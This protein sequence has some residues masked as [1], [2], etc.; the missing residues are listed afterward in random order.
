MINL[1]FQY[2]RFFT[3]K[4][5]N[6][7]YPNG[8]SD[9]FYIVPTGRTSKLIDKM[10][11]LVRSKEGEIHILFDASNLEQLTYKLN[12]INDSESKLSFIVFSNNPYFINITDIPA[13]TIDK[14]FYCSNK[15]LGNK[16]KGLL[17]NNEFIGS[18]D[19][20]PLI[21]EKITDY[22]ESSIKYKFLRENEDPEGVEINLNVNNDG[23]V[24]LSELLEGC[25]RIMGSDKELTS[26]IKLGSQI[27]G[28]PVGFV[29]IFLSKKM[30]QEII[31]EIEENEL[32]S[33]EYEINFN[34][35]HIYWKYLIVPTHIKRFKELSV[36]TQKGKDKLEFVK[37][38][39]EN[40]RDTKVISFISKEKVKFSKFYEYDIQLK[41]TDGSEG[42]KTIIKKMPYAP[43]DI[44]K[45]LD[46]KDFVSEI[47]VYI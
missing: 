2:K 33:Y 15:K 16:K 39:E 8:I 9:D 26:F 38:G 30:K 4:I 31:K 41:K 25:Y 11:L 17:H 13:D 32:S 46:K 20:F 19:F 29:D 3:L 40:I 7:Y 35:R 1:N 18:E 5:N 27:K 45:P 42:G 12:G 47:Y 36:I 14:I 21:P 37:L 23:K 44:I 22:N 43:F 24:E 34:S 10:S 28:S 6:N